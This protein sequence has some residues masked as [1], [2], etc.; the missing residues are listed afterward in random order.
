MKVLIIYDD[1][2]TAAKAVVTLQNASHRADMVLPW[3]ASPWRVD[4]L[5][6]APIAEAALTEAAHAHLVIFAGFSNQ[7]FPEYLSDWL[8]HWVV[9]RKVRDVALAMIGEGGNTSFSMTATFDLSQFAE[10]HG[11]CIITN[12]N[13]ATVVRPTIFNSKV[14][15]NV[16]SS[17]LESSHSSNISTSDSH[18]NWGINE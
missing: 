8:E 18:R 11:L 6:F 14:Y 15:E 13:M 7:I 1:F 2:T 10:R 17:L 4:L 16:Q 9:R 5:K 3:R 12:N